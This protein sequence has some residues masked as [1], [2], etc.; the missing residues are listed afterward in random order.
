MLN[1]LTT[2]LKQIRRSQGPSQQDAKDGADG[3]FVRKI[4]SLGRALKFLTVAPLV[5][6][7]GH[8]RKEVYWTIG[9][10]SK[11]HTYIEN[12]NML[13]DH[14][15]NNWQPMA[16]ASNQEQ[17]ENYTFN[18]I[19]KHN[20]IKDFVLAMKKEI[21]ENTGRGHWNIVYRDDVGPYFNDNNGKLRTI[22]FTW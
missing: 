14:T 22:M 9:P 6:S 19:L 21:K 15:T 11:A 5:A 8:I 2:G 16:F 3:S 7:F 18:D 1:L 20:E 13:F 4:L 17:N 10:A 12:A